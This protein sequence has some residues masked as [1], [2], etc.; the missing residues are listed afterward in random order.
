MKNLQ[1]SLRHRILEV[2]Y[3]TKYCNRF[4]I[5]QDWKCSRSNVDNF[6]FCV[7]LVSSIQCS[8]KLPVDCPGHP[9]WKNFQHVSLQFWLL[10]HF[11]FDIC[12]NIGCGYFLRSDIEILLDIIWWNRHKPQPLLCLVWIGML[13]LMRLHGNDR[14]ECFDGYIL[15]LQT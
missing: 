15:I 10:N 6:I 7:H 1:W 4:Q 14:S 2:S 5:A 11:V 13:Y 12:P 3:L 9:N 8:S